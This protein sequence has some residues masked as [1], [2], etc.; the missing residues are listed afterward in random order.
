[1]SHNAE[2]GEGVA[3]SQPRSGPV[4]MEPKQTLEI[5]NLH[6][7]EKST[8]L[9]KVLSMQAIET[10]SNLKEHKHEIF[11]NTFFAETEFLWYQGPATRDFRILNSIWPK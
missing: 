9:H 7:T 8:E 5:L 1:M 10:P 3:R 4:H 2:G 6:C 11:L